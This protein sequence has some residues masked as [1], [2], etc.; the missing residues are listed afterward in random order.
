MCPLPPR[1][2]GI[3]LVHCRDLRP[4]CPGFRLQFCHGSVTLNYLTLC[5]LT[6]CFSVL[7]SKMRTI[8]PSSWHVINPVKPWL[9]S[10]L[11]CLAH[12]P[13]VTLVELSPLALLHLFPLPGRIHCSLLFPPLQCV[14]LFYSSGY[15]SVWYPLGVFCLAEHRV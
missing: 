13:S 3:A 4:T 1:S 7:I 9:L 11:P 10:L 8:L 15:H 6:L 12:L 2:D 14:I 5:Y